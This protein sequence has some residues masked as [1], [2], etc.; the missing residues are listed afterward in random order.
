MAS[1]E[2]SGILSGKNHEKYNYRA[3]VQLAVAC[4][5]FRLCSSS[6]YKLHPFSPALSGAGTQL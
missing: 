5:V 4:K 6:R 2:R 3:S 1:L